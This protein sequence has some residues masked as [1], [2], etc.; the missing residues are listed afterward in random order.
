MHNILTIHILHHSDT[1]GYSFTE[2]I[3][4]SFRYA[5]LSFWLII[6][7]LSLKNFF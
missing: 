2:G 3:W 5:D 6:P 7:F 4:S 1:F